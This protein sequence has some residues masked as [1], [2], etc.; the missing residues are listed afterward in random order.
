MVAVVTVQ[1]GGESLVTT[2]ADDSS[3]PPPPAT[4]QADL[5]TQAMSELTQTI[6][7]QPSPSAPPPPLPQQQTE[8]QIT[9]P[10]HAA[11]TAAAAAAT[12]GETLDQQ[13]GVPPQPV[14]LAP[15]DVAPGTLDILQ[16]ALMH[17]GFTATLITDPALVQ[18]VQQ[19]QQQQQQQQ[20]SQQQFSQHTVHVSMPCS[21]HTVH[22]STWRRSGGGVFCAI[23]FTI[24]S[25]SMNFQCIYE[26][27]QEGTS[28]SR[29]LFCPHRSKTILDRT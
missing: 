26:Q 23:P 19:Q 1:D 29:R 9:L 13:Q 18:A 15:G 20:T 6:E 27:K 4:Q 17:G 12:A 11:A 22:V 28:T 3:Q 8:F 24:C 14:L 7:Y 16:Q 25:S 21:Q 5:L 10:L 2:E